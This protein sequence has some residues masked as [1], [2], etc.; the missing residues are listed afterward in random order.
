MQ[1]H[2]SVNLADAQA[3]KDATMAHFI[4]E[5]WEPGR[6]MIHYNGAG[7]SDDFEG[8]YWWLKQA[9]PDLRILTISTVSAETPEELSEDALGKA[10]F[11][12]SVPD[13]MTTT[14]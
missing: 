2:G 9:R 6:V 3:I 5:N 1:G 11:I 7:H 8:I 12:I 10:D 14:Y 13:N 4:L